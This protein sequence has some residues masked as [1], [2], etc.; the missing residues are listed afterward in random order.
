MPHV[1]NKQAIVFSGG[2]YSGKTTTMLKVKELLEAEGKTVTILQNTHRPLI[3]STIDELRANP[4][5]YLAFQRSIIENRI[6]AEKEALSKEGIVLID[7]GLSDFI[8]Y[9]TFYTDKASLDAEQLK[10]LTDIYAMAHNHAIWSY[11]NLY[12]LVFQFEPIAIPAVEALTNTRP[13]KLEAL[14][15]SEYNAINTLN[16]FY[17]AVTGLFG[18]NLLHKVSLQESPSYETAI[19]RIIN[20]R[21]DL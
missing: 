9:L 2:C 17:T 18:I 19:V 14:Q 20:S 10:E 11:A 16:F 15:F 4:I 3:T 6:E 12:A 13:L 1:K 8:F 5:E 7:R 21:I